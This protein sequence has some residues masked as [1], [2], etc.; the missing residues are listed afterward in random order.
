MSSKADELREHFA[1][2]SREPSAAAALAETRRRHREQGR[3]LREAER[4]LGVTAADRHRSVMIERSRAMSADAAEIGAPPARNEELWQR[5]RLDLVAFLTERFPRTTGRK[6]FSESHHSIIRRIQQTVLDGGQ[7]LIICFRGAAKSTIVENTAIW[8]AGYGHRAFFVPIG[9]DHESAKQT[10]DSIQSEFETNDLLMDIFPAACH[11]ARALEGVPQRAGKQTSNGE[12][13]RIQWSS[14]RCVLPTV[15][16]FEGSGAIIW[17]KGITA[18]IRGLRFKRADG[19]QARPDFVMGDDLQTDE[20]AASPAQNNKR[21]SKINKTIL[22]LGGHDKQMSCVVLGTIIE[23]DDMLDQLSNR[24]LYPSWRINRIPMLATLPTALDSHWLGEYSEI[25]ANFN[26]DDDADKFRAAQDA[27]AFYIANRDV[28][29]SGA[30]ATWEHCYVP[31]REVSAVQH[32]MNILLDTTYDAFM[33]EC[34][35]QPIRNTGGLEILTPEQICAKQSDYKRDQFPAACTV[36]TCRVDVHPS[37]L[38][39]EVWAWEPTFTGY[40]IRYGTFPDQRRKYFAH[41]KLTRRLQHVFP[42]LDVDATVEAGLNALLG[43][44]DGE[45]WGGLAHMEWTRADGTPMRIGRGSVDANGEAADAVKKVVRRFAPTFFTSFGRGIMARGMPIS[46]WKQSRGKRPTWPEAVAVKA[47]A[48][49]PPGYVYDTNYAK[50]RFHRALAL[51]VGSKGGLY[52]YKTATLHDHRRVADH[53][54]SEKPNEVS[55]G[56]RVVHEFTQKP[57]TDNHDF[58]CAVGAMVDAGLWGIT[59]V[60]SA[61]RASAPLSLSD[62]AAQARRGIS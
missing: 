28:M 5:Y 57:G 25:R 60:K 17:P 26:P 45:N 30:K 19:V 44:H 3:L 33:A 22:R 6:P 59:S 48:G 37:I 58:D 20:S 13:T 31:D 38:Y 21:L 27:T 43:G 12:L 36:L 2:T 35:N 55:F 32:A 49:E 47:K 50:T 41:S 42:G 10:L 61:P 29:D 34:Q 40:C 53:W 15:A 16:G 1:T 9:A 24:K 11:C 4:K 52:L 8:A 51:P 18:N 46:Q 54:Y 56:S 7:E 62:Y 23:P 39:Y 14:E